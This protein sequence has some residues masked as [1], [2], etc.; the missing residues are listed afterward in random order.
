[1]KYRVGEKVIVSGKLLRSPQQ[2]KIIGIEKLNW[3]DEELFYKI[4]I[5]WK[6]GGGCLHWATEQD[7]AFLERS[8]ERDYEKDV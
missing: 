4:S 1:M 8:Y 6:N 7:I 3:D 5:K 2:G